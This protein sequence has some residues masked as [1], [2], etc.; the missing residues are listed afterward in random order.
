MD[1]DGSRVASNVWRQV[2]DPVIY[3]GVYSA[4]GFD[5]MSILVSPNLSTTVIIP[6]NLVQFRVASRPDPKITLGA[7]DCSVAIILCDLYQPDTPIIYASQSFSDLTGYSNGEILGRNC[8]FLQAPPGKERR[9]VIRGHDKVAVHKM[10]QA[11]ASCDEIQLE[12]TNYKKNGQRFNN[13]LSIVPVQWDSADFR[14]AVGFL[15][16]SD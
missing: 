8:R 4:T 14:Y 6:S 13:V 7:V 9:S 2:Q 1:S 11:V 15:C 12:V 5:V 10:R 3:P 16:E